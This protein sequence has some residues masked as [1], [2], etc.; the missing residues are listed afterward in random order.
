MKAT[1]LIAVG[2][3]VK[4]HGIAGEVKVVP[5]TDNPDRFGKL[6]RVFLK[7]SQGL[8]ELTVQNYRL[9]GPFVLVKFE[10]V[11]DLTAAEALGRGLIC[12]PC[13][14]RLKLPEGRYYHDQ[15]EGLAVYTMAGEMLGRI[16]RILETGANDVY[17][18]NGKAGEI[19]IPA[20]KQVVREIDLT[21]G[22][23][24]VMLPEGLIDNV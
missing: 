18:V 24:M 8:R 20:L 6:G 12:I 16:E 10:G 19:L 9:F 4:C 13:E 1:N 22:K 2:E 17:V 3:I 14:E 15:L 21:E 5:L 23:I 11:P 7:N